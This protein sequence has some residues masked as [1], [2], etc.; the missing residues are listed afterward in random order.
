[1]SQILLFWPNS[2]VNLLL[3]N[4]LSIITRNFIYFVYL[5][6]CRY[7]LSGSNSVLLNGLSVVIE[8]LRRYAHETTEDTTPLESLPPLLAS[9]AAKL[10]HFDTFLKTPV[11]TNM[12]TTV[13]QLNPLGFYRLKVVDFYLSLLRTRY[14]YTKI[15]WFVSWRSLLQ[16]KIPQHWPTF[17]QA[18]ILEDHPRSFL[19]VPMEQLFTL[20]RGTNYTYYTWRPKRRLKIWCA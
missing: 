9:S 5:I 4:F 19:R 12:V 18:R 3:T 17:C 13:G 7:I 1:M 15:D 8:L 6:Y 14:P 20:N 10:E 16:P 11:P 2:K